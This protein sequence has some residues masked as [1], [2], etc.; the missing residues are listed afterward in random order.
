MRSIKDSEEL[1]LLREA[2]KLGSEGYTH[3]L[4]VLKEGITEEEVA[5][6]LEIF[7]KKRKG[8]K[9]AFDPII[10]F[11]QHTSM[12]HYR[13]GNTKLKKGDPI[14]IDIG[15]HLKH[16]NSDMTR[17]VFFGKPDPKMK[18]IY[19]IVKEA[20]QRTLGLRYPGHNCRST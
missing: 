7:W 1:D 15:V 14:L 19:E 17:M 11:G 8:K 9:V 20:Q 3:I 18:E 6:E 12:P 16:Y 5:E 13:S 2:A 4:G 10:A